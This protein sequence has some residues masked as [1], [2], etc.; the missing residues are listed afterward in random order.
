MSREL[1]YVGSMFPVCSIFR[2]R[3]FIKRGWV[4][5][6]GEIFKICYDISKLNFEDSNVMKEQLTGVDVAYF[7]EVIDKLNQD[8]QNGVDIDRTY[9]F[10]NCFGNVRCRL[11]NSINKKKKE[12]D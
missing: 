5:T 1:K 12:L 7:L 8:K 3:K 4:I 11:K 9:I 6:A 10:K 2:I